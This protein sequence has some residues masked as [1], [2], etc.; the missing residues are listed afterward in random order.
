MI[1]GTKTRFRFKGNKI[2]HNL[3]DIFPHHVM[4]PD[5]LVNFVKYH[6]MLKRWWEVYYNSNQPVEI[7]QFKF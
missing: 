3:I 5:E 6:T 4:T 1:K 7:I 2:E